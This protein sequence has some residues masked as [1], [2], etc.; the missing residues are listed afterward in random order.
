MGHSR[1]GWGRG[2]AQQEAMGQ[3]WGTAGGGGAGWGT[4]EGWGR[5]GAQQEGVGEGWGTEEGVGQGGAQQ[6]G[7]GQGW[8]RV[9]HRGGGGAGVGHSMRGWGRRLAVAYGYYVLYVVMVICLSGS[10][11]LLGAMAFCA[12][13][14]LSSCLPSIVPRL[15]QVLND[16]HV[17]VQGAGQQALEQIGSV[18]KN[19]EIQGRRGQR[20]RGPSSLGSPSPPLPLPLPFHLSTGTRSLVGHC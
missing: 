3:G 9:G 11:E 10:V 2:G 17:K 20:D 19:P 13:K 7:V 15:A 4:E 12:P 14:Q 16:S 6:E 1:R 18:I 5:G 8:G